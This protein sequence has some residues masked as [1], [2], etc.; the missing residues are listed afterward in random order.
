MEIKTMAEDLKCIL[1]LNRNI[2]GVKFIF[3]KE[4][5]DSI[6]VS[7]V[8][9]KLS[10]CNMVKFAT[11]GRSFKANLDNFLCIGSAKALGLKEVDESAIAGRVYYSF[12][13]YDSLCTARNVQK[14]V[15]FLNHKIYGVVVMP[16][17]EY[18][19]DPDVVLFILNP[20]Q[21]MRIIQGYTYHYRA[22]KNIKITGNSGIC[23]EC[24]AVPYD[25]NDLNISLLCSNTRFSAKWC[26][27]ELG[28]GMPFNMFDRIF[29]GIVKTIDPCEPD[30]RKLKI[31]DR[32]KRLS[33]NFDINLGKSYFKSSLK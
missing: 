15:T 5:F 8:K 28:I 1:D 22:I 13:M 14:D 20:Y 32:S 11:R 6:N 29:D 25:T 17:E 9:G 21:G 31:I 2:V 27:D 10:Y 12:G 3:T 16:L 4:E 18:Q 24:T 26:D 19:F 7:Q 30:E 23:S 33:K